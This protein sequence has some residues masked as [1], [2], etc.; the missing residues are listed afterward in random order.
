MKKT[1][2]YVK[3]FKINNKGNKDNVI[4][5]VRVSP[6]LTLIWSDFTV[7]FDISIDDFELVN[8]GWEYYPVKICEVGCCH[9]LVLNI[10]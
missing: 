3:L 10:F 5:V 7:C 9:Y 8:N 2:Q 6:L 1:E 4:D